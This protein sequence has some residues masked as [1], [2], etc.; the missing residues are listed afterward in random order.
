MLTRTAGPIA[1][2]FT[3]E[4]D[5]LSQS[6]NKDTISFVLENGEFRVYSITNFNPGDG[7]LLPNGNFATNIQIGSPNMKMVSATSSRTIA[8]GSSGTIFMS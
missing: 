3:S 1:Q 7:F 2:Q 6:L 8:S 5:L 4:S